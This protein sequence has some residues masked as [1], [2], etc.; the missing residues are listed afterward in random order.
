[1]TTIAARTAEIALGAASPLALARPPNCPEAINLG[2]K[3]G[4][5]GFEI[6]VGILGGFIDI[7]Q[8]W[9]TALVDNIA[10]M[11]HNVWLPFAGFY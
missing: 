1:M 8:K 9:L 4:S 7:A 3:F 2:D 6:P 10:L 5:Y 11:R